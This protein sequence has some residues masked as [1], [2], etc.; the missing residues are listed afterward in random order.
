M[1]QTP[2]IGKEGVF[3]RGLYLLNFKEKMEI[4]MYR[5]L[6]NVKSSC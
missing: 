4:N 6:E 5:A 1:D 3:L 2:Y